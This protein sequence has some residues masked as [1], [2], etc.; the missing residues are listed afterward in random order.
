MADK[1]KE[2]ERFI[3]NIVINKK[4]FFYNYSRESY[5]YK[6]LY[7]QQNITISLLVLL[8]QKRNTSLLK[9]FPLFLSGLGGSFLRDEE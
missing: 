9:R 7:V 4:W 8:R 2:R 1:E 5:G 6:I 3:T